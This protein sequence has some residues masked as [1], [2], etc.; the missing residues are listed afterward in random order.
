[1]HV[2]VSPGIQSVDENDVQIT[3]QASMLEPVI[4]NQNVRLIIR[5]TLLCSSNSITV[6]NV[7]YP[8]TEAGQHPFFVIPPV[9]LG[10]GD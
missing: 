3:A 9:G 10:M 6:L 8:G 4:G 1:M 2:P 7:R 5:Y